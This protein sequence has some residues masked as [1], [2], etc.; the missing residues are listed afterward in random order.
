MTTAP[1]EA[2]AAVEGRTQE[3]GRS[4]LA[5]AGRYRPGP[6]ERLQDWLLTH[7]VAD[8]RF[9]SRLLRYMDVL[10]SL[11]YDEGGREAKRLAR[12]YFATD[13]PGLPNSLRWLLRVAR[14]E[15]LPAPIVG[16][17]ARRAASLFARRFITPP[18]SGACGGSRPRHPTITRPAAP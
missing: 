18:G 11:D 7:A 5:E 16:E 8:D 6:A 14:S 17:T 13:F 10:A 9:R 3:L 15:H 1:P 4:L 12:E 2:V